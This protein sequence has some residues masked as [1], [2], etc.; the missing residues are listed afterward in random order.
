M[1]TICIIITTFPFCLSVVLKKP[2]TVLFGLNQKANKKKPEVL[3]R[4]FKF[5]NQKLEKVNLAPSLPSIFLVQRF[6]FTVF[7][8]NVK[9]HTV[10]IN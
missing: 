6:L 7:L 9:R 2:L 4:H 1:K 3:W 5:P 8:S 10:A